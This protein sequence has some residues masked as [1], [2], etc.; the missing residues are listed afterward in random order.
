[1]LKSIWGI[2]CTVEA[3]CQGA[4]WYEAGK[5]KIAEEKAAQRA[6]LQKVKVEA[7]SANRPKRRTKKLSNALLPKINKH[8]TYRQSPKSFIEPTIQ[9]NGLTRSAEDAKAAGVTVVQLNSR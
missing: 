1:M 6:Q 8:V 5:A 9:K 7:D 4:S 3:K 2:Q